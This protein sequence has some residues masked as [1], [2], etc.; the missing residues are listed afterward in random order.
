MKLWR[1]KRDDLRVDT[2]DSIEAEGSSR[3]GKKNKERAKKEKEEAKLR[4]ESSNPELAARLREYG[5]NYG[6][7]EDPYLEGLSN[8][9]EEGKNL[10]VW[11]SNDVMTLMPHPDVESVEG[12][13]YSA[14]V[15]IRNVLV[16]VPVALTWLAVG[17]ATTA[18]S[19]YTAQSSAASVVNFLQFWQN[20]Y[21]VLSKTWT[22]SHVAE[23][24]FYIIGTVIVLTFITPFMNRSAV[25]KAARFEQDALRE[26]LTLV[27]EVESFLFDKRRLT[28]LTIDSALAQSFE[29][30]VEATHNLMVASKRIELGL[31]S[32]PRQIENSDPGRYVVDDESDFE[33]TKPTSKR[34][35]KEEDEREETQEVSRELVISR[36][37]P[38]PVVEPVFDKQESESV[39]H[40]AE[41]LDA[42]S[43]RVDVIVQSLP[44]RAHARKELKKVE[45]ELDQTRTELMLLQQK[46]KKQQKKAQKQNEWKAAKREAERNKAI[47]R[48][49]DSSPL[50]KGAPSYIEGE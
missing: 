38:P 44:R 36:Q 24:D 49:K 29:R 6:L 28:P 47:G 37:T 26:R 15:L 10:A 4:K 42:V 14:M 7:E 9:I 40:A 34:Q 11:A 27:I 35:R 39:E 19:I 23:D 18:F 2:F 43:K 16:F 41:T 17:K 12:P 5:E 46:L 45:V 25:K 8:A 30:V 48:P 20:G 32:L 22:L 33:E 50:G 3:T 13:I 21:G 1:K 31:K